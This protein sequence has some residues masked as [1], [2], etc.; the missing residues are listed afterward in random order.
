MSNNSAEICDQAILPLQENTFNKKNNEYD[1]ADLIPRVAYSPHVKLYLR[2]KSNTPESTTD[3]E[4]LYTI[5]NPTTLLVKFPP[6]ASKRRITSIPKSVDP[7]V[8][9]FSFTEILDTETSQINMFEHC[10]KSVV[11]DFLSGRS[12][13]IMT[14]GASN[15]GKTHTLHGTSSSPGLI[16]RSIEHV[17]ASVSCI[18][19]PRY[20]TTH[21]NHVVSLN[22]Q[23]QAEELQNKAR[24]L[25]SE[26]TEEN[27]GI[28]DE[29]HL[30]KSCSQLSID[31]QEKYNSEAMYSV[32]L[33]FLEI[34]NEKVYDLL[35][36]DE[37][38]RSPALKLVTDKDGT[39][40]AKNATT[41]Y[42]TSALEACQVLVVGQTRCSVAPTDLNSKSSRSHTIFTL[43]LLKYHEQS[44][45]DE[46]RVST[47]TF[48]D[49]AAGR[50]RDSQETGARLVESRSINNSLLVLGRC[51]KNMRDNSSSKRNVDHVAG[52]FRE[53][54]LTRMFQN[55][56]SGRENLSLIVTIDPAKRRFAEAQGVLHFCTA[57]G[58]VMADCASLKDTGGAGNQEIALQSPESSCAWE[59]VT[60]P[61]PALTPEKS[62]LIHSEERRTLKE[63]NAR[64]IKELEYLKATV[65]NYET[66]QEKNPRKLQ[67]STIFCYEALGGNE[68]VNLKDYRA[69][70]AKNES[71]VRE[72]ESARANALNREFEVRQELV[73]RYSGVIKE[74]E[75]S[76]RE[77][78]KEVE[79]EGQDLLKWSV[80]QVENFYRERIHSIVW[81][82][83]RKRIDNGDYEDCDSWLYKELEAENAQITSKVVVLRD[84]VKKLKEKNGVMAAERNKAGFELALMRKELKDFRELAVSSVNNL[85]LDSENNYSRPVDVLEYVI[86][87][88]T[89]NIEMLEVDL[90]EAKNYCVEMAANVLKTEQELSET[91]MTL[92]ELLLKNKDLEM[93]LNEK[94]S[95]INTLRAQL[96]KD[97]NKSFNILD[98]EQ[99]NRITSNNCLACSLKDPSTFS[100]LYRLGD[101]SFDFDKSNSTQRSIHESSRR[102]SS[103]IDNEFTFGNEIIDEKLVIQAHVDTK[104]MRGQRLEVKHGREELLI[105]SDHGTF[106]DTC[107]S[108][109]HDA[110]RSSDGSTKDDSGIGIDSSIRSQR[111]TNISDSFRETNENSTQTFSPYEEKESINL[112]EYETLKE[113]YSVL[114]TQHLQEVSRVVEL[115][116]E[117]KSLKH[118]LHVANQAAEMSKSKVQECEAKLSS[119]RSEIKIFKECN[120]TI[121]SQLNDLQRS[122]K[123]KLQG[124]ET[125]IA[126]L[127]K[128]LTIMEE[129]ES[130]TS[131]CLQGYIDE[132]ANQKEQLSVLRLQLE[133]TSVKRNSEY[134]LKIESL[135]KELS[136]RALQIKRMDEK[137]IQAQHDL[138]RVHDLY[139]KVQELEILLRKCESEKKD[140]LQELQERLATQSSLECALQELCQRVQEREEEV[141]RLK[142]EIATLTH[143]SLSNVNSANDLSKRITETN[144]S[145]RVV[146]KEL[147]RSEELRRNIEE[148]STLEICTLKSRLSVFEKNAAFLSLIKHASHDKQLEIDRLNTQMREKEREMILFKRNRDATI[149][150]YETLVKK[151]QTEVEKSRKRT[152]ELGSS[153][154]CIAGLQ[155]YDSE[156]CSRLGVLDMRASFSQIQ[157]SI[158]DGVSDCAMGDIEDTIDGESTASDGTSSTPKQS[159]ILDDSSASDHRCASPRIQAHDPRDISSADRS[160]EIGCHVSLDKVD[161]EI[162]ID[163]KYSMKSLCKL[164]SMKN[165]E[166]ISMSGWMKIRKIDVRTSVTLASD[167]VDSNVSVEESEGE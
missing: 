65:L 127:L 117:L 125:K 17:F 112:N 51:L 139:E 89:K 114:K 75:D 74:L 166:R 64:L 107:R 105:A 123:T 146:E 109:G 45:P 76:W 4:D 15:S 2:F 59:T 97:E 1:D 40:H 167:E 31:E 163:K 73:D 130:R 134:L 18:P 113:N 3:E 122:F 142:K 150:R 136:N 133:D 143:T 79:D 103:I 108:I 26:I 82:K 151:L 115:S 119:Q 32:W 60:L 33:S 5:V 39:V 120:Y 42:V 104:I 126:D 34:Y 153:K 66:S 135:E 72:L 78:A 28:E 55:S 101:K 160:Y 24:V 52:P 90:N 152:S 77:R 47:L 21:S 22:E 131:R 13:T 144:Q 61:S 88:K 85:D 156:S 110:L 38:E 8:K 162:Q 165:K 43:R 80:N 11:M 68:F 159:R 132:A 140:F 102:F 86:D 14:Y 7:T 35:V 83:K 50:S 57:M 91:Q 56:L 148:T 9:R 41:I 138:L 137:M 106:Q 70:R 27:H 53:S 157:E 25:N 149:G 6:V 67:S 121:T 100:S 164:C 154:L 94:A 69:L 71:L 128:K 95:Y 129:N 37:H 99:T 10:A 30:R 93:K 98:N 81:G 161:N 158:K 87:S 124:Y 44:T 155:K 23:S 118:A 147:S 29:A 20:K 48:C 96:Q 111:S 36:V 46:V 92:K 16:P 12:S 49:L 145:V 62:G 141:M 84:T 19:Y 116:E 63:E 54:K 58:K